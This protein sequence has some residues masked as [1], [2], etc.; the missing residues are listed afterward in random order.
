MITGGSV[1]YLWRHTPNIICR[2][3]LD[4]VSKVVVCR[5]VIEVVRVVILNCRAEPILCGA[6][7]QR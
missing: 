5:C 4:V 7:G 2:S 6:V 1:P 3:L